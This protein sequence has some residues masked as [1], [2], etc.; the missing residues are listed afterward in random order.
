M[1]KKEMYDI[2]RDI[3]FYF[4]KHKNDLSSEDKHLLEDSHRLYGA[5][6]RIYY[7]QIDKNEDARQKKRDEYKDK[8]FAEEDVVYEGVV[9]G[10]LEPIYASNHTEFT[11]KATRYANLYPSENQYVDIIVYKNKEVHD[12]MR[13]TRQSEKCIS[14][15]W[16]HGIWKLDDTHKE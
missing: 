14:G 5:L 11:R 15:Q 3:A 2:S 16:K 7:S 8:L 12:K 6:N 10:I 4:M 1:N 9:D 13:W